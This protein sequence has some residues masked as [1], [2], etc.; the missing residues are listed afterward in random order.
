METIS[1]D[2]FTKFKNIKTYRLTNKQKQQLVDI[3][4][5]F[6]KNIYHQIDI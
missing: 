4:N 5:S 3:L 2:D 1:F 6:D